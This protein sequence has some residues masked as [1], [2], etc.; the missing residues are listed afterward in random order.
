MTAW[1]CTSAPISSI[2]WIAPLPYK[3]HIA[4]PRQD[5]SPQAG[6]INSCPRALAT[7]WIHSGEFVKPPEARIS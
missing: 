7:V 3:A 1:I 4:A 6:V 5:V 2:E